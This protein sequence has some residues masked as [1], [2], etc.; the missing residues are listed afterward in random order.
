MPAVSIEWTADQAER[1][2]S[3]LTAVDPVLRTAGYRRASE[4]QSLTDQRTQYPT[5]ES[6][7]V[8]AFVIFLHHHLSS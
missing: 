1:L 4:P 5:V 3:R 2:Y 8:H 7:K 6:Y